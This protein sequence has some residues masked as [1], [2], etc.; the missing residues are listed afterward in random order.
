M[1]TK[2][3]QV[4]AKIIRTTIVERA[5]K[6]SFNV[7]FFSLC[8]ALFLCS[9]IAWGK[10][11]Y[12]Y[13]ALSTQNSL[14]FNQ[15]IDTAKFL[16]SI[17]P[18]KCKVNEPFCTF[19]TWER[20][21]SESPLTTNFGVNGTL[22]IYL[23]WRQVDFRQFQL[24]ESGE[25]IKSEL[26]SSEMSTRIKNIQGMSI[27]SG[28]KAFIFEINPSVP[29]KDIEDIKIPNI[30][31]WYLHVKTASKKEVEN[32][33]KKREILTD[34][35]L[36]NVFAGASEQRKEATRWYAHHDKLSEIDTLPF[37]YM[38]CAVYASPLLDAKIPKLKKFLEGNPS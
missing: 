33:Y 1:E 12:V 8:T 28:G 36:D 2:L 5:V 18:H 29:P 34:G 15:K 19:L 11:E 32:K 24:G 3:R 37:F 17:L 10:S 4:S 6:A 38:K 26:G 20:P 23:D 31:I 7:Y 35:V 16:S 9:G 25:F 21:D 30:E 27:D 14:V 22:P 13:C